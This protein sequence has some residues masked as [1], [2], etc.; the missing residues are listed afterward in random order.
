MQDALAPAGVQAAHI[1]GL[2]QFT[3]IVCML[4]FAGV[5]LALLV[6]MRK[7]SSARHPSP[8]VPDP[9]SAGE[10]SAGRAVL[11]ATLL[12][13]AGLVVLV[14]ADISTDRSLSRLAVDDALHIRMVGHSW[15]WEVS[16]GAEGQ[17]PDF[18]L[19][20]EL[21][22]PVGRPV[23]IALDS[24]DVIHTFW[25]PNLHGKK[26]M[27][28]G[29]PTTIEFRADKPGV[30]RGQCAEFCG[31]EHALM[32]L[33][34]TAESPEDFAAWEASQRAPAAQ[35]SDAEA[36]RGQAIFMS[37]TCA[38]CH[39]I[40]G[41]SAQGALGPD[42]THLAGRR[43]IAAGAIANTPSELAAWIVDPQ[44]KKPGSWMPANPLAPD[45]VRALVAYLGTLQ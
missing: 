38:Q 25:V 26:D 10:R 40:K 27:L 6:A 5:L 41:T 1:Y 14:G 39:A 31:Q 44:A 16:Y 21:H 29:R 24:V 30:Y 45:D 9:A 7:G 15:W 17:P 13:S 34:V 19:A 36:L 32:A 4:V 23:V 28:P 33:S 12:S 42:L 37:G 11:A 22:V 43:T 20:N 2:W 35:P 18:K 8:A 3:L